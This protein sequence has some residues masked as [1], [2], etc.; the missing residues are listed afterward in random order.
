MPI[1]SLFYGIK[2]TMYYKDHAPPHFHASYAGNTAMI[3]ILD[4]V[5]LK[6]ALPKRQLKLVL[7]W[8]ELHKDELMQNWELAQSTGELIEIQPL[9]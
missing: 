8:A 1:I 2:I 4:N 9:N 6:S 7:A 3:D 5:V